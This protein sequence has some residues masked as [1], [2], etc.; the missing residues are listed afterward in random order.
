MDMRPPSDEELD[1]LPQVVLTSDMDWDPTIVDNDMDL[2]QWIDFQMEIDNLPG[3][4][5]YGDLTFDNQG[6][7]KGVITVNEAVFHD[8]YQC[9]SEF[10]DLEDIVNNIKRKFRV[11]PKHRKMIP[12]S[13][14][15][16]PTLPGPQLR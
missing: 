4:N 7:Y 2:E 10:C 13:K 14:R 3:V 15:Y 8:S 16:A 5:D 11:N 6:Y 1:D 9:T 12:T